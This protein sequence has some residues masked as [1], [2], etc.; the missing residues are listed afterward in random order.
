MIL[1]TFAL[2]ALLIPG[3]FPAPKNVSSEALGS[4][5]YEVRYKL[6]G[7]NTKVADATISLENGSWEKQSV[8]H[9]RASIRAFS[10]FRLFMNAEYLADAYLTPGGQEPVYSFNP[11]KKGNKEG[12]FSCTYDRKAKMITSEFV[13]PPA[14][15]VVENHPLDGHTMD[16]L[17]LLQYVRFQH[18][19]AG[20]SRSLLL[21]MGA[22]SVSATLTFQGTDTERFPGIKTE[23][24][25][26]KMKER[27]LMENGSG[28]EITVWRSTGD[29][30]R[31]LGLETALSSGVMVVTV[32]EP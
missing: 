22:R 1:K 5:Q 28:N 18:F 12:K 29:D 17:S 11:I 6:N 23:R 2:L 10:I 14:D 30:C 19:K 7:L 31:I 32:K 3:Q 20:E 25:L 9:A 26:L 8:L 24:F 16:M 27:G 13:K 4:V 15:P 21:L